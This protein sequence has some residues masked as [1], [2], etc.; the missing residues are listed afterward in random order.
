MGAANKELV[1]RIRLIVGSY[2]REL[3]YTSSADLGAA[4]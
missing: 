2:H 4:K 1:G 3:P